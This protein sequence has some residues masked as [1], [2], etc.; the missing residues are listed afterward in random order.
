[1]GGRGASG[2][3]SAFGKQYSRTQKIKQNGPDKTENLGQSG[4]EN[5]SRYGSQGGGATIY[6]YIEF[7]P[8]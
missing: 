1:M 4:C 2:T 8:K 6:M 7:R 5:G 3:P